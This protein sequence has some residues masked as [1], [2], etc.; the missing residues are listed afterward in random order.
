MP[1]PL[2]DEDAVSLALFLWKACPSGKARCSGG[3]LGV[4]AHGR[5]TGDCF[6]CDFAALGLA[7]MSAIQSLTGT[8]TAAGAGKGGGFFSV[9]PQRLLLG[10]SALDELGSACSGGGGTHPC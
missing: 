2:A 6:V 8:A 3:D 10:A 7:W 9:D 1:T 5:A 4:K